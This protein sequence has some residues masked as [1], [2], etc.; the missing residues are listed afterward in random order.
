MATEEVDVE[1]LTQLTNI[2]EAASDFLMGEKHEPFAKEHGGLDALRTK[3]QTCVDE[4]EG[5]DSDGDEEFVP[6]DLGDATEQTQQCSPIGPFWDSLYGHG[7]C[8]G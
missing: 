8:M 1:V 7:W 4:Y 2:W 5:A 3:L 6:V